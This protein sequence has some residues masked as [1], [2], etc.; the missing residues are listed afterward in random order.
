MS[1]QKLCDDY[2][3][4]PLT[5]PSMR[6]ALEVLAQ[7]TS[8]SVAFLDADG[9]LAVGPVAGNRFVRVL[10]GT[11][12]GRSVVVSAHRAPPAGPSSAPPAPRLGQND[13][14]P[15]SYLSVPVLRDGA[16]V[17]TISLTTPS[18]AMLSPEAIA[19][20]ESQAGLGPDTLG[21]E[22]RGLKPW[23]SAETAAARDMAALVGELYSELCARDEDLHHR[24]DELSTVYNITGMLSG[25]ADLQAVL[26]R[27]A[28]MV[29]EV[30]RVKACSLRMLDPQTGQLKIKAVHNLSD[31]YLNKG[32]VLVNA[33]PIDQAALEGE[34]VRVAD[35][36]N[37]PRTQYP[38]QARREG[39]V[40]SLVCGMRYRGKAVGVLRVYTGRPHAF[41]PLEEA[42]LRAV[43]SQAAAAI[44]N[45]R[46]L[47]ET[48]EAQRTAQQLAYAGEVQRRMIP[49]QPPVTEGAEIGAVYRPTFEVGGD[50]YD[51]IELP[52]QNL[53][54]AIADVVGKGVP[55]SLMMA[56]LRSALRVYAHF[57]YDVEQIAED[58][59]R[60]VYRDTTSGEFATVFY[61]V[62]SP[63]A[64]RL[65]YCNAGH[66][67]PML[68]RD[69]RIAYLEVGGMAIGIDPRQIFEP[70]V[71]ELHPGDLL[72][73]YT[74]GAIEALDFNDKAFG[75]GR[76]EAS[77]I[78]HADHPAQHVVKHVLW[79]LRRF[80]G[81]ADRVD[82]V[83][84]V[85]V[86]V[87]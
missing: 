69:G 73:L 39:I 83:T 24:M 63:D 18:M 25:T 70:D 20:I 26:D 38:A 76:L 42:L 43:A 68:L 65:T 61:G 15:P 74:D 29:S 79:D 60:H 71:L 40:S 16:E 62:L 10:L 51:F 34:I 86:K 47:T 5:G 7:A 66:N 11:E 84:L 41:T 54:I 1:A 36:P 45:A 19:R 85:A 49:A 48:L 3:G 35:A 8:A 28:R 13:P 12:V 52:E 46:L 58:I 14:D 77:L 27:A 67:P 57:T 4:E 32:P 50:F 21:I 64:R 75:L 2:L 82:D 53:G 31:E 72:L 37:D 78:R 9:S 23:T 44:V 80:R 87:G 81:L 59:N 6:H 56:S 22:A 30:M 33:N 55:A 17:G